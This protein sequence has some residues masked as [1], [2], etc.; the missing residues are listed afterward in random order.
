[1]LAICFYRYV[2]CVKYFILPYDFCCLYHLRLYL[3]IDENESEGENVLRL[4][5]TQA[6]IY[7]NVITLT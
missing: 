5:S 3:M 1:M 4:C 2:Y 6:V 7:D